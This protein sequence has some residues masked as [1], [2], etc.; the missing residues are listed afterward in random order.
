MI[1]NMRPNKLLPELR[2]ANDVQD[3]DLSSGTLSH[4]RPTKEWRVFCS[5]I[6]TC[7]DLEIFDISH[8]NVYHISAAEWEWLATALAQC[9]KLRVIKFAGLDLWSLSADAWQGFCTIFARCQNLREIDLSLN[10]LFKIS[11][12]RWTDLGAALAQCDMLADVNLSQNNVSAVL[13]ATIEQWQAFCAVLALGENLVSINLSGNHLGRLD[14]PRWPLFC[15]ALGNC[16]NLDS[17][18]LSHN[19]LEMLSQEQW[20]T[21]DATFAK[22]TKLRSLNLS[23]NDFAY[24]FI[25]PAVYLQMIIAIEKCANLQIILLDKNDLYKMHAWRL[26]ALM[27]MLIT[28]KGLQH[29]SMT[30]NGLHALADDQKSSFFKQLALFK[31]LQS[32]DVS[33]QFGYTPQQLVQFICDTFKVQPNI[34]VMY[35]QYQVEDLVHNGVFK[36]HPF[37]CVNK[38]LKATVRKMHNDGVTVREPYS[39]ST[40]Q[41]QEAKLFKSLI[42]QAKPN[43]HATVKEFF[44]RMQRILS[45]QPETIEQEAGQTIPNHC[46]P[47]I[48][49]YLSRRDIGNLML[50]KASSEFAAPRLV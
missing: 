29:I 19:C 35:G 1:L 10:D 40:Y 18:D 7:K 16:V 4:A 30:F 43:M 36:D 31:N 12:D 20:Q 14:D 28:F 8:N 3:L 48:Y 26:E 34:G 17:I 11:P 2:I 15:T 32:L 45:G 13:S 27:E 21:L 49:S 46:L 50:A 37:L 42:F 38:D 41:Q 24:R 44:T 6:A 22:W 23:G 39:L 25:H 33:C 9:P 47:I 5:I